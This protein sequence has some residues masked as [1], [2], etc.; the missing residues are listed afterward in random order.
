MKER[1][2]HKDNAM[3]VESMDTLLP[4]VPRTRTRT[5]K[6]RNSWRRARNTRTS[7]KGVHMWDNNG[8]KVMKMRNQR[9]KAWQSS[10]WHKGHL[11]HTSSTTSPMMRTTLTFASWQGGARYKKL[12]PQLLQSHLHPHLVAT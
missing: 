11:H 1:R 8:T 12:S 7:T 5:R 9:N 4:S 2:S 3:S 6:R 10:P